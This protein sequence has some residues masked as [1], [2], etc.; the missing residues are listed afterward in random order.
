[1]KAKEAF[2][3]LWG[4]VNNPRS[5]CPDVEIGFVREQMIEI[6]MAHYPQATE[7]KSW[8]LAMLALGPSLRV[9]AA[10]DWAQRLLKILEPRTS[11]SADWARYWDAEDDITSKAS[12]E[13]QLTIDELLASGAIVAQDGEL[14]LNSPAE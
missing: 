5:M 6:L 8:L 14:S 7:P 9:S 13:M 3:E 1:M 4:R 11:S 12:A 10:A 2:A